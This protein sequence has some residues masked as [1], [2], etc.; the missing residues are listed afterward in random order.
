[1]H[2]GFQRK[3]TYCYS[4]VRPR[5]WLRQ[6]DDTF[7][8]LEKSENSRF[9]RY[10]NSLDPNDKFIQEQCTSNLLPFLDRQMKV[11]TDG[12]LSTSVFCKPTHTDQYLRWTIRSLYKLGFFRK[13]ARYVVPS[14]YVEGSFKSLMQSEIR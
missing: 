1:M 5:L 9:L 11:N 13:V 10:L 4:G 7:F 6:V 8:L 14:D 12:S 2:G 3:S